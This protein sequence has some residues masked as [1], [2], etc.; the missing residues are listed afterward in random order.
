MKTQTKNPLITRLLLPVICL[1]LAGV[2]S[3]QAASQTWSNAPINANWNVTNNWIG[4]A[5]PGALNLT[6][7]TV[8]ND[9]ATFNTPIAGTIGSAAN[10]ILIDDAT[11]VN[12]R[13]R[14]LG[15]IT[16]DTTSCGA[17]VFSSLSPAAL[18][19]AT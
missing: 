1:F 10:P 16:F 9:V 4:Q 3:V 5:L 18:P 17:Y 19:T 13:S 14:Q 2:S 7:N 6:G 11:I 12:D 8:N 15:G